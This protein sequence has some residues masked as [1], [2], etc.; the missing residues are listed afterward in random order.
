M[1]TI[2]QTTTAECGLACLAMCLSHWDP[3]ADLRELRARLGGVSRGVDL[4]HLMAMAQSLNLT[5]R[6][7]RLELDELRALKLPCILHWDL[8]H[9]VVLKGFSLRGKAIVLDPAVGE[10]RLTRAD[11]SRHFTGVA[12]EL[13]PAADFRP[14]A[15]VPRVSLRALTG[16]VSGLKRSLAQIFAVALVLQGLALGAPLLNQ[17]VVDDVLTSG[18]HHLLTVLVVGFGL[19]LLVQ[20]AVGLARSWMILVLG[21]TVALQ[22]M[23]NVFAHLVR[24]PLRYFEQRHAGD[25]S[26]RFASVGAIQQ[27]LTTAV[28][29]ALLDGLMAIAALVMMLLYA[30]KL[31]AV[32]VAAV[33][34][35]ALLRVAFYRPFRDAAAERLVLAAQENTHFL[36]TLRGMLPLKLFGRENERRVRWQNLVVQV[37]NRDMQTA[38]LGLVFST[39]HTLI[40][41]VEN[42]AVLALGARAI[43]DSQGPGATGDMFTVGMLFAFLSY[44]GQF[45]GRV[46]ALIDYAVELRMLTLHGERLADIALEPPEQDAGGVRDVGHLPPTLEL[47]NVSFRYSEHEPWVLRN[48]NLRIAAGDHVA[49]VGPSG[50]GKTTLLKVLL[51]ILPPQ[52]G[53]VLYGGQPV[54][55]LG[56][57]NVRRQLG[58]VMQDDTLLSG[59]LADN[60]SFFDPQPDRARVEACARLAQVHDEILCMPMGFETLVGD[61]GSGLSGGQRQRLLLARALYKQP[62]VLVLDEATSH[63]DPANERAVAQVLAQLALTRLVIAHRPETVARARRVVELRDG[64]V[65]EREPAAAVRP[66]PPLAARG[67]N[68]A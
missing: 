33:A 31:A 16:S 11:L 27:T 26:A 67:G 64:R 4:A 42:L 15:T 47:R 45:T 3:G 44:K 1:K 18:D 22:W 36:E 66:V 37:Q 17:M 19:L 30:P 58:T 59:S 54:R 34:A 65:L 68:A 55:Q 52:E 5:A 35:Y 56:L 10:R 60:I 57:T 61:L 39:A 2:L 25:I 20:T 32:V 51:G 62:R 29:E 13:H 14:A 43:L 53:E 46:S 8:N 24:L 41:G 63:L 21:Q 6:P 50:A 7:L 48:V 9:F 12:L 49:V 28:V 38:K 40:F 23:T